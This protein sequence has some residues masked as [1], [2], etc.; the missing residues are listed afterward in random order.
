M[1]QQFL[2][3][4]ETALKA[5]SV[6]A[7]ETGEYP[8][9]LEAAGAPIT[10]LTTD[11][12][13][14]DAVRK[15]VLGQH[16][17]SAAADLEKAVELAAAGKCA[18]LITD[19]ALT[20]AGFARITE[21]LRPHEPALVT[22]AIGSRGEDNV[23]LGLMSS[24][25]VDRFMLKPLTPALARIVIESAGREHESRK[26]RGRM[27]PAAT[28]VTRRAGS[29]S[30]KNELIRDRTD[31]TQ[32]IQAAPRTPRQEKPEVERPEMAATSEQLTVVRADEQEQV[33]PAAPLE[34]IESVAPI[35]AQIEQPASQEAAS[36]Q[37]E[38]E[39]FG[40]PE[41][42]VPA[43][44]SDAS[45][46]TTTPRPTIP[47]P[48]IPRP[49][50][51]VLVAAMAAVGGLVWWVMSQ[52]MPDIDPRQLIT[53]NL[54][55]AHAAIND[56]RYIEPPG[57]SALQYFS[58]VLALDSANAEAKAGIDQIADHF[59]DSAGKF[60]A[61]RRFADA[62]GALQGV[63]RVRPEHSRLPLLEAQLRNEL[64]QQFPQARDTALAINPQPVPAET[65]K[66]T[67]QRTNDGRA[68]QLGKPET[69][70]VQQ[71]SPP[72]QT[73]LADASV[74]IERGQL[75]V[76]R[77]LIGAVRQMGVTPDQ[78][79]EL[80][81]A[82]AVAEQNRAEQ[83]R[84]KSELPQLAQQRTIDNQLPEPA[85]DS[86]PSP[87]PGASA[88]PPPA[89]SA[90]PVLVKVVEPEYPGEARLRGIEGWVD[91]SFVVAASGDVTQPRVENSSM[92]HLFARP[93]LTAVRQWK[94][95]PRPASNQSP[96]ERT[97][98]RVEFRLK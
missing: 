35:D 22:V 68:V 24:E 18:I 96:S 79:V 31:V 87:A 70:P 14:C 33:E 12:E 49:T 67:P 5:A 89:L 74:A 38:P 93:A 41:I 72:P 90:E 53:S 95:Q 86:V 10:V 16:E 29:S 56:G 40:A 51:I 8:A 85:Q 39:Q 30:R 37:A 34:Q 64:K 83:N 98:V 32:P 43:V 26:P 25:V 92:K 75:D 13:L 62:V 3:A 52:R 82:L 80:D 20:P 54:S 81:Q 66:V 28:G 71:E 9:V 23:L 11:T 48:T 55:A 46:Q 6:Y 65:P 19:Q 88:T 73:M 63:R 84:A 45:A 76:A 91:L 60:I 61:D 44:S 27:R 57:S 94:Y 47:R 7:E 69:A 42:I 36:L 50:W 58:T 59:A 15:A 4:R 77:R 78:L 21:Q 2:Q 17:V 97:Q 1:A